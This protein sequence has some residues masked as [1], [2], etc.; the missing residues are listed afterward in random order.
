[1]YIV[2]GTRAELLSL[3]A[4]PTRRGGVGSALLA[5]VAD[6]AQAEGASRLEVVTTNDNL[7]ALA[8][9]QRRGLRLVEL[10]A[11]AVDL[12]RRQ[13]PAIPLVGQG[14][15][16]VHDALRLERALPRTGPV[17]AGRLRAGV[18]V[19]DAGRLL[20]IRRRRD[21]GAYLTLPGGGVEAGESADAAAARECREETGLTV[22][23]H[24]EVLRIHRP[25]ATERYFAGRVTGG[26]LGRG[27]GPE[28]TNP[29]AYAGSHEPLWL[30]ATA[31]LLADLRPRG[32]AHLVA[33]MA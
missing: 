4:M 32:L 13:K 11:A 15:T 18:I 6:R 2:E 24:G 27:E 26:V 29:Q 33:R 1:M 8:F 30:L 9:Y 16:E 14:G 3:N 19:L 31:S 12:G 20:I 23:C 10:R 25:S 5:F 28:F 21:G 17:V 7:A 22:A